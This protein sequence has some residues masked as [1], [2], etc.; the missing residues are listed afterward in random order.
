[1][2]YV[3]ST[4]NMEQKKGAVMEIAKQLVN[5]PE[6][7]KYVISILMQGNNN[8]Y[9]SVKDS[10]NEDLFYT[11]KYKKIF[12]TIQ[13][14]INEGKTPDLLT[15]YND[16]KEHRKDEDPV[17]DAGSL[18]DIA[19]AAI[20]SVN[21]REY[22]TILQSM[23]RRRDL[24]ALGVKCQMAATDLN[25]DL[26]AVEDDLQQMIESSSAEEKRKGMVSLG[27]VYERLLQKIGENRANGGAVGFKTGFRILDASG[28]LHPTDL[29]IVAG[30]T[31]QGKSALTTSMAI[32]IAAAGSPVAYYS[33]EMN[34]DQL[35]AR[36]TATVTGITS[37]DI[38]YKALSEQQEQSC[39][40]A[41]ETLTRLPIYF[42]SK[43]TS[44]IDEIITS[45][46]ANVHN[47]KIKVAIIDYLQIL[48]RNQRVN[49]T[50]QFY[51]D[52]TRRLKNLAKELDICIIAL[53][54]L[55]RN[56]DN[57]EPS[58][59]RLR[60]SGQIEEAAD[61]VILIYRP[62][63]YG[64]RYSGE[65]KD[66]DTKDTAEIKLA[67]GRNVGL[68]SEIIGFKPELTYFYELGDN[69]PAYQSA[70]R[71]YDDDRPF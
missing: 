28:G 40:N 39:I 3:W 48:G 10:L 34:D 43:S 45:I 55:S 70:P 71:T 27:E 67:K 53:S 2:E 21:L 32:N 65:F 50:E 51:G 24:F 36:I 26:A 11:Q 46:R 30:E 17:V 44:S 1:M 37:S 54:Q 57:P 29:V 58:I 19:G 18:A 6:I 66:A 5:D 52:V 69:L 31:S 62:I 56:R 49:S 22:V 42:D 61:D 33:M 38:L 25:T 14:M 7:E 68:G 60:A 64:K 15:V 35:A 9:Y 16:I 13:S 23:K 59:S 12:K 63:V 20:S 4:L 41:K 47:K 8:Y